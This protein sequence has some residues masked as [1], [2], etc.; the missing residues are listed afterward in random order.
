MRALIV[1]MAA[2]L[3]TAAAQVVIVSS[4]GLD[5]ET[6][7]EARV[8]DGAVGVVAGELRGASAAWPALLEAG[9]WQLFAPAWE[10]PLD[11]APGLALASDRADAAR[12]SLVQPVGAERVAFL[13][14]AFAPRTHAAALDDA[15]AALRAA[16]DDVPAGV[17]VV[18]VVSGDRADAAALLR[19]LPRLALALVAG[20][21]GGDPEPVPVGDAW[22]MEV[23]W[24][25]AQ[26]GVT[27]AHVDGERF[28]QLEHRT[29]DLLVGAVHVVVAGDDRLGTGGSGCDQRMQRSFEHAVTG[30]GGLDQLVEQRLDVGLERVAHVRVSSWAP[31]S[32][33]ARWVSRTGR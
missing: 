23:P 25:G 4:A 11:R 7:V 16:L 30:R 3:A 12:R 31:G 15:E 5:A 8:P 18:L 13:A 21:G 20:A 32:A 19:R 28:V 24:G 26:W 27:S 1:L 22:L 29:L 6:F 9:G 10:E 17:P 14:L 2:V 33:A